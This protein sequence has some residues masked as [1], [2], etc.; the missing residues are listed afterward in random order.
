MRQGVILVAPPDHDLEIEDGHVRVT[1][2]PR[3]NGH[4]PSI[5]VLFRS[6][7]A[8]LD[9]RVVGVVLTGTRN[10]GSAGLALIKASGGA[11]IVQD[12]KEAMY[13]G[14]PT[15]AIANVA[16]DAIVPSQLVASTIAAM[17]EGEDPPPGTSSDD[18][19]PDPPAGKQLNALCPECGAVLSERPDA[20]VLQWE[21]RLG[22]RYSP[23]TLIDARADSVD[24]AL[25]AAIQAPA[26]RAALLGRMA[27]QA[28]LRGQPRSAPPIP[29]RVAIRLRPGRARR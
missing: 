10:D 15:S 9:S 25:S 13:P 2:A 11:T 4:R 27:E 18:S 5:D 1:A 22:H 12:P 20:G 17:V 29:P 3:E 8:A 24:G 14:M 6:A 23:D 21:C 7:A 26:A 16:V 28:E 19:N